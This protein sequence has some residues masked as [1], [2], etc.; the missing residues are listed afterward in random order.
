MSFDQL[1]GPDQVNWSPD[2]VGRTFLRTYENQ[3]NPIDI[4]LVQNDWKFYVYKKLFLDQ[5]P[6]LPGFRVVDHKL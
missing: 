6:I 4:I 2:Q 1:R 3:L 5:S